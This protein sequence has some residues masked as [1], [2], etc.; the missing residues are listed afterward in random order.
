[1]QI[2]LRGFDSTELIDVKTGIISRER[3]GKLFVLGSNNWKCLG[4]RLVNNFGGTT[5][6]LSCQDFYNALKTDKGSL[7]YKNGKPKF[8]VMD[9]DHGTPR[10]WGNRNYKPIEVNA[11]EDITL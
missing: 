4:F 2:Q 11:I 5:K 1:M 8:R 9:L 7:F 6:I 10:E 3:N